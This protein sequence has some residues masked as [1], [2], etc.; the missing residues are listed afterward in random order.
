MN[1]QELINRVS[2]DTGLTKNIAEIVMDSITK[3]ITEALSDGDDVR[4]MGFGIFELKRY[5]ARMGR[6]PGTGETVEIPPR[7]SPVFRAGT[8]LKKA[9]AGKDE[10]C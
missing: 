7:T 9:V 3:N 2:R 4:I 5:S 8:K 10:R 1:K 6:V